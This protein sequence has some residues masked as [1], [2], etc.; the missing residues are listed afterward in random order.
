MVVLPPLEKWNFFAD[1]FDRLDRTGPPPTPMY[2]VRLDCALYFRSLDS[3][4]SIQL[5]II[6]VTEDV[7]EQKGIVISRHFKVMPTSFFP[8][9]LSRLM[10][11]PIS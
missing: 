8:I 4:V 2:D 1:D 9:F 10:L 3:W 7:P 6:S 11:Y 5:M